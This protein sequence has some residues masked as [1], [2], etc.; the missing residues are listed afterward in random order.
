[1][2]RIYATFRPTLPL[3]IAIHVNL[4]TAVG[5]NPPPD[6][7]WKT[8]SEELNSALPIVAGQ[9]CA[10]ASAFDTFRKPFK[11]DMYSRRSAGFC[12]AH[13]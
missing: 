6:S 9:R 3:R 8:M 11:I 1:M 4:R 2:G 10:R 13:H 12:L 5:L 7:L